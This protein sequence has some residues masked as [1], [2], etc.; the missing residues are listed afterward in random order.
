MRCRNRFRQILQGYGTR[1]FFL[2]LCRRRL[3]HPKRLRRRNRCISSLV[4]RAPLRVI[5]LDILLP[6]NLFFYFHRRFLRLPQLPNLCHCAVRRHLLQLLIRQVQH[7][8]ELALAKLPV[9]L[10]HHRAV[11]VHGVP[12]IHRHVPAGRALA[13]LILSGRKV[14]DAVVP[15]LQIQGPVSDV[16]EVIPDCDHAAPDG[17][18]A[19]VHILD[20]GLDKGFCL[21]QGDILI[22]LIFLQTFHA[23]SSSPWPSPRKSLSN[24]GRSC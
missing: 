7:L 12:V 5:R 14:P 8:L 16:F 21:L 18:H 24:C 17:F 3:I 2:L 6:R 20:V 19:P 22:P 11:P 13:D 9:L 23:S 4:S 1:F 10:R 15:V